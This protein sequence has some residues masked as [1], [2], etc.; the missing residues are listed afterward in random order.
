M[1]TMLHRLC[2]DDAGQDLVEY[3]LLCSLLAI[4]SIASLR[5]LGGNR[6]IH[7]WFL[8]NAALK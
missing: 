1:S 5:F 3:A 4:V 2:H 8:V 6:L 7:T